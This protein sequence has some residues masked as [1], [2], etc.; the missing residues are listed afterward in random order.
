MA[1][2]FVLWL[3]GKRATPF[4]DVFSADVGNTSHED[5][6]SSM[7]AGSFPLPKGSDFRQ[8]AY[9]IA[10]DTLDTE[11]V[12]QMA[13]VEDG[14]V[15]YLAIP[16]KVLE[17][18][19]RF[20]SALTAALPGHSGHK[21]SGAY[22]LRF[23]ANNFAVAA[24]KTEDGLRIIANEITPVFEA[25][26][27][28]G[29]PVIDCSE[30]E[31]KPLLSMSLAAQESAYKI[32]G[33]ITFACTALFLIS[34][35]AYVLFNLGAGLTGSLI[36]NKIEAREAQLRQ[37]ATQLN[38]SSPLSKDLAQL[39]KVSATVSRAGGWIK[40]YEVN[41][42]GIESFEIELPS[43]VSR[44]Y[45]DA[46]GQGV[47]VDK[48]RVRDLLIAIKNPPPKQGASINPVAL[49]TERAPGLPQ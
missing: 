8:A 46:L 18:N 44:D 28:A 42:K 11:N 13:A 15:Y 23:P 21:G 4:A 40:R 9:W 29:L 5:I 27:E 25:I 3:L 49:I 38:L 48:D 26:D 2:N 31:V 22:T 32:G 7:A 6:Y 33:A 10:R 14:R 36:M 1:N 34:C 30:L 19:G 20:E 37:V 17:N 41:A 45:I 43:W 39:T 35:A 24:L 47:T 12:A 16:S